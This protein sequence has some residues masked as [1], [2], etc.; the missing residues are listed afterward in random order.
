MK[1]IGLYPMGVLED[2]LRSCVKV[3]RAVDA[4]KGK[5]SITLLGKTL[6][7]SSYDSDF[8]FSMYLE[9]IGSLKP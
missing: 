3:S 7:L 2:L 9:F 4:M 5:Q 1:R 8:H 6:S